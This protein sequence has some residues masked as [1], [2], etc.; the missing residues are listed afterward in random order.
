MGMGKVAETTSVDA[1]MRFNVG[2]VQLL[3]MLLCDWQDSLGA[4][5]DVQL[6]HKTACALHLSCSAR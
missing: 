6:L 1:A 5:G 4:P 3:A 2:Y